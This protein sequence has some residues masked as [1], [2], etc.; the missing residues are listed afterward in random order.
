MANDGPLPPASASTGVAAALRQ[1]RELLSDA[2]LLLENGRSAT[3]LAIAILALEE[4]GKALLIVEIAEELDPAKRAALWKQLRQHK[5]KTPGIGQVRDFER[6]H[7]SKGGEFSAEVVLDAV[8]DAID[9]E[10]PVS[11]WLEVIKQGCL[12]VESGSHGEWSGPYDWAQPEQASRLV[13]WIRRFVEGQSHYLET[14][15]SP[16]EMEVQLRS[17]AELR[18]LAQ[19]ERLE[20]AIGQLLD[21]ARAHG[22]TEGPSS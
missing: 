10:A 19:S 14:L 13:L 15:T 21:W 16:H 3:A 2:Q 4:F 18:A 22:L 17:T 12:Y 11:R 20:A 6:S 7:A 8:R 5:A 9:N 1:A